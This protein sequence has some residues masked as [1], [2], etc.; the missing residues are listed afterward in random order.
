MSADHAGGNKSDRD[1]VKHPGLQGRTFETVDGSAD[2]FN[3]TMALLPA[4][5]QAADLFIRNALADYLNY[6]GFIDYLIVR[7]W[8]AQ[9]DWM[10]RLV[11]NNQWFPLAEALFSVGTPASSSNLIISEFNYNPIASLAEA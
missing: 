8:G 7:M 10:G 11:P 6:P 1:V 9:N 3:A 5:L 2:A 4:T